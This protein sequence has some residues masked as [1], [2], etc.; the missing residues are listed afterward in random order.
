MRTF[1][2]LIF[3]SLTAFAAEKVN[4]DLQ[5]LPNQT[6]AVDEK[7]EIESSIKMQG[8]ESFNSFLLNVEGNKLPKLLKHITTSKKLI[9]TSEE[10]NGILPL[11]KKYVASSAYIVNGERKIKVSNSKDRLV[12]TTF[13]YNQLKNGDLKLIKLDSTVL[14]KEEGE[15]VFE[16]YKTVETNAPNKKSITLGESFTET[17]PMTIPV[18]DGVQIDLVQQTKYLLKKITDEGIAIFDLVATYAVNEKE[19]ATKKIRF[20][21]F[22]VGEFHYDINNRLDKSF[23]LV[24]NSDMSYEEAGIVFSIASKS[25]STVLKEVVD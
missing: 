20:S 13:Y 17:K 22:G 24:M 16:L 23:K 2:I 3:L 18:N 8:S 1:L 25:T 6:I 21:G 5:F 10:K 7:T 14:G 19:L 15:K 12:D 11:E 4:V 9:K